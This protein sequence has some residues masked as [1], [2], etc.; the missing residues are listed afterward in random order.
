MNDGGGFWNILPPGQ[1]G[2]ATVADIGA[3]FAACPPP[4]T[5]CPN[6]PRPKHSS[7]ELQMYGDLVYASPGLSATDIPKYFK[8]AIFG[9]RQDEAERI[10]SPPGRDDVTIVRDGDFGVPHIY[11]STRAGTMFGLGYVGR[12]GPSFLHG[13]APPLRGAE[14]SRRSPAAL[15]ATARRTRRSGSSRPTRR[16]TSS[17]STTSATRC[18]GAA[19]ARPPATT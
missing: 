15:R 19:G 8:D 17:A 1:N 2:H 11:G 6:A 14:S 3:F 12:G 9:V 4:K 7:K 5:N 13:R 16:P 18:Y 10:Y